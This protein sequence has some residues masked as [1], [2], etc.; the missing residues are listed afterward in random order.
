[1]STIGSGMSTKD[2]RGQSRKYVCEHLW[3]EPQVLVS[4]LK[5]GPGTCEMHVTGLGCVGGFQ[6]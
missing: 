5:C 3:L 1:M 4:Q 2:R 6:R